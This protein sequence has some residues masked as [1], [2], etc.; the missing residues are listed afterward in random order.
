M[1]R[2]SICKC[3][4]PAAA[5]AALPI[6]CSSI[7]LARVFAPFSPFLLVV[8]SCRFFLSFLLAFLPFLFLLLLLLLLLFLGGGGGGGG[9]G[10]FNFNFVCL[11]SIVPCW[12]SNP[13]FP[14]LVLCFVFVVVLF[15]LSF[16]PSFVLS[17]LTS[18][19]SS[20]LLFPSFFLFHIHLPFF[21]FLLPSTFLPFS[22]LPSFLPSFLT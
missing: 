17:P 5:A 22:F 14:C 8:P 20:F 2:S 16:S 18:H 4:S 1:H 7:L 10:V 13:N 15:Y 6:C 21:T 3:H 12:N 9:G 11:F 19:T